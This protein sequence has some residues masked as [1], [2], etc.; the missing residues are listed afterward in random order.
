[1]RIPERNTKYNTRCHKRE[2]LKTH[3]PAEQHDLAVLLETLLIPAIDI[4]G[5]SRNLSCNGPP[6]ASR[7]YY[8]LPLG[9]LQHIY[10]VAK[11]SGHNFTEINFHGISWTKLTILKPNALYVFQIVYYIN[12]TAYHFCN[13]SWTFLFRFAKYFEYYEVWCDLKHFSLR[14][15]TKNHKVKDL[16]FLEGVESRLNEALYSKNINSMRSSLFP[17]SKR[18]ILHLVGIFAYVGWNYWNYKTIANQQEIYQLSG[19]VPR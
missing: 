9:F 12:H 17:F 16:N 4:V 6:A 15:T 11:I 5:I 14:V 2:K 13:H 7:M 8:I 19:F 3:R 18:A 10:R 1:M